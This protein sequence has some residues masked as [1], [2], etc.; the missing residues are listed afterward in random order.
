MTQAVVVQ[1]ITTKC[2]TRTQILHAGASFISAERG[3]HRW[4]L[5]QISLNHHIHFSFILKL[6][7]FIC[8]QLQRHAAFSAV[9]HADA[10]STGLFKGSQIRHPSVVK[11]F[12][13]VFLEQCTQPLIAHDLNRQVTK[14]D[15]L[16][17]CLLQLFPS[18]NCPVLTIK[19]TCKMEQVQEDFEMER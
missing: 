1:K 2:E 6:V 9:Q 4:I 15:T 5:S 14:H 13:N 3:S 18:T 16:F 19:Q 10:P 12:F 8:K 7:I 11:C 17:V